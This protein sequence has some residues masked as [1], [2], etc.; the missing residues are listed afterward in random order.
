M[1]A[2]RRNIWRPRVSNLRCDAKR[3]FMNAREPVAAFR[4]K[5]PFAVRLLAMKLPKLEAR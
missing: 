1:N 3:G 2:F 5:G 4:P